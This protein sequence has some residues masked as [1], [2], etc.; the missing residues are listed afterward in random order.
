[1]HSAATESTATTAHVQQGSQGSD[2]KL[3]SMSASHIRVST[4]LPVQTVS[5]HSPAD[6][7]QGIQVQTD[8]CNVCF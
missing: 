8:R 3:I 2:A 7:S 5:M 6:V 4:M 1:M